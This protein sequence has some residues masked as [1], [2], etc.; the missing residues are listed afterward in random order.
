[1]KEFLASFVSYCKTTSLIITLFELLAPLQAADNESLRQVSLQAVKKG[2]DMFNTIF[3]V[4]THNKLMERG[5]RRLTHRAL[6][7]A[8][9]ISFYR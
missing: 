8:L 1:M 9:M 3:D 4:N 7:G 6:Q 2:Q 5:E